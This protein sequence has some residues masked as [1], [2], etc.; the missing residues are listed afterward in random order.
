MFRF[1]LTLKCT[2][3][4]ECLFSYSCQLCHIIK[5]LVNIMLLRYWIKNLNN[6]N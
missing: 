4:Y 5:Y 3:T 6:G 1:L 2:L